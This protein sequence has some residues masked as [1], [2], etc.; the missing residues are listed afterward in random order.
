MT[1]EQWAYFIFNTNAIEG[2]QIIE[3]EVLKLKKIADKLPLEYSKEVHIQIMSNFSKDKQ[4]REW[5]TETLNGWLCCRYIYD[6]F[7]N[8]ITENYV[9]F[10][11]KIARQ[12]TIDEERGYNIG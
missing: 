10:I 8:P 1:N 6:T 3:S 7:D 4:L 9:K 12:H 5:I 11:H 2:N